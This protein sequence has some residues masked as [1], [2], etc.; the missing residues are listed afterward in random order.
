MT[1][2]NKGVEYFIARTDERL[3]SIE[4]KIDSLTQFKVKMIAETRLTAF[5]V[6]GIC[7]F[8]SMLSCG[9]ITYLVTNK[10]LKS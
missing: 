7:G 4:N 1:S 9:V 6:S 10:F 8:L 5:I 2:S 3:L